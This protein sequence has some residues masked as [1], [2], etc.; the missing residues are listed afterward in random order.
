MTDDAKGVLIEKMIDAATRSCCNPEVLFGLN[1]CRPV[2]TGPVYAGRLETIEETL[3][4]G[5]A[6]SAI[7]RGDHLELQTLLDQGTK[8]WEYSRRLDMVPV[9]MAYKEGTG[10]VI[11]TL[12]EHQC[13]L[14][15]QNVSWPYHRTCGLV[16]AARRGKREVLEAWITALLQAG[17]DINTEL[18]SAVKGALRIGKIDMIGVLEKHLILPKPRWD[19]LW[20]DC[21]NEGVKSGMLNVVQWLFRHEGTSLASRTWPGYK[22]PLLIALHKCPTQE[23]KA[24]TDLLLRHGVDPDG[25]LGVSQTPLQRAVEDGEVEIA[26]LLLRWGADPNTCEKGRPPLHLAAE[27][28]SAPLIQLLLEYEAR[29]S[30]RI[31]GTR[32]VLR[33]ETRVLENIA[34][35]LE[36]LGID[37]AVVR[38]QKFESFVIDQPES[39]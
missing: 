38:E 26:R 27:S 34:R 12:V 2:E 37:E 11:R 16:V 3:A 1:Y 8:P 31:Q 20:L 18:H 5:L 28:G 9:D 17:E 7:R 39:K 30:Y 33:Q 25:P 10:E 23:K 36:D 6:A 29:R 19:R 21:L 13:P 14:Y 15:Y 35:L 4:M 24:M 32:H 22:A